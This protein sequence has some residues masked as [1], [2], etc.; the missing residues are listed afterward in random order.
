MHQSYFISGE[1]AHILSNS[2]KITLKAITFQEKKIVH[3]LKQF[4]VKEPESVR[5]KTVHILK[6]VL[7]EP[8]YAIFI[9][10]CAS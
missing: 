10:E 8:E 1:N 7:N 9:H 2:Y 3:K 4:H 5:S 6:D